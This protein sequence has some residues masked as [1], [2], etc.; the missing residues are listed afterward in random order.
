MP[1]T[2]VRIQG[3]DVATG[4]VDIDAYVMKPW[5]TT[6]AALQSG[7]GRRQ[8]PLPG[9]MNK[10]LITTPG[11]RKRTGRYPPE[12]QRQIGRRRRADAFW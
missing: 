6:Q 7:Q 12:R 4:G 3:R 8:A 5:A 11:A 9:H 1:V 2:A 10:R